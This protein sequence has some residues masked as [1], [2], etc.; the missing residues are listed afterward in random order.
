MQKKILHYPSIPENPHSHEVKDFQMPV[1]SLSH[2]F[3]RFPRK[4]PLSTPLILFSLLFS[5][6]PPPK[7]EWEFR[8]GMGGYAH[9]CYVQ[10]IVCI[11]RGVLENVRELKRD[12]ISQAIECGDY[13]LSNVG[14]RAHWGCR[15][16]HIYIYIEKHGCLFTGEP[17]NA[18][19]EGKPRSCDFFYILIK[20]FLLCDPMHSANIS[21]GTP[22]GLISAFTLFLEFF[23]AFLADLRPNYRKNVLFRFRESRWLPHIFKGENNFFFHV[24]GEITECREKRIVVEFY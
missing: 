12:P 22:K 1:K 6:H 7:R 16:I 17:W 10:C 19:T 23:S 14:A 9:R 13:H 18:Q 2:H 5:N 4:Q 20:L 21:R 11:Y 24:A 3:H 8:P 15:Y